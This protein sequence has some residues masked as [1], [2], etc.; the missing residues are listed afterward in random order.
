MR[1]W[2]LL[3][4]IPAL[5]LGVEVTAAE[6]FI[7]GV[8]LQS[9]E[10]CSKAK[11]E[12]LQ[13]VIDEGNLML[14]ANGIEG[15][16]YN[17]EFLNIARGQR[18]PAWAVTALCQEPGHLFPDV[19]SILELSPTQMELTSVRTVDDENGAVSNAG[20]YYLCDGVTMP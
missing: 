5:V 20:T 3:A 2:R 7:K 4:A 8:Y 18:S 9:E 13:T 12:T 14:S 19:L 15:V 17:C 16:E 10:L 6:E 1:D 11:K